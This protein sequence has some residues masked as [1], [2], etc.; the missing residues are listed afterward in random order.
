LGYYVVA[1]GLKCHSLTRVM[2][3]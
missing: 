3:Q 2:I 1:I